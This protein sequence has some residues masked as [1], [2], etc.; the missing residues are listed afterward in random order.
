MGADADLE[1]DDARAAEPLADMDVRLG[2][3]IRHLR[4]ARGLSLKE[5]AERSGFSISFF[6]QIERGLSSPSVRVLASL[7]HALNVNIGSLFAEDD[8][9]E[10][11]AA[12]IVVRKSERKV[13]SFW[14]TGIS[15]ELLTPAASNARLDVY[16]VRMDPGGTTGEESYSHDG[17]EAGVVLQGE[18]ELVVDGLTFVLREGDGFRFES[19][20]PHS[21][22][23]LGPKMCR[24]LWV[25][26]RF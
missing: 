1:I 18:M 12:K 15:K 6:S 17:E 5:V 7:A 11:A 3:R 16:L 23:N 26:A 19:P 4:K 9:A 24:V 2:Q 20:R 25:N 13:L 14:R 22:R 21:F 10:D 8:E